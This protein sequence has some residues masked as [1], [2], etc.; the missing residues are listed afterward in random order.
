MNNKITI[1]IEINIE[2]MF[3]RVYDAQVYYILDESVDTHKQEIDLKTLPRRPITKT[4]LYL[5]QNCTV[6][7]NRQS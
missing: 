6:K 5:Q 7:R 3:S 2:I 1:D 4:G